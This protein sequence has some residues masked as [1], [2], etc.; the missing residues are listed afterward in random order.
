MIYDRYGRP[1]TSLRISLTRRCNLDC[2]YCHRE[3]VSEGG[4]EEMTP[5]EIERIIRLCA[6]S[7]IRRVKL[8]GGEPLL[9]RDIQEIVSRIS[10][11]PGIQD[12]SMTTNGVLLGEH[13]RSLREAGLHRVNVSLDTLR[14]EVFSWI[15]R[16]GDLARVRE[17]IERAVEVGLRP[18]K[19]NMVLLKGINEKEVWDLMKAYGRDGVVLQL[20]EL[21]DSDPALFEKY[22]YSLDHFE[23]LLEAE[24]REVV[25]RREMQGRKK[26]AL[27]GSEVEVIKPMHNTTFCRHC[28]RLRITADG[29]FKPCL[30]RSEN[31]VD[32][33]GPMREG[34][35]DAD[36]QEI[37][38]KAVSQR[39]PYF[40]A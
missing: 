31:T 27:N 28:T 22:Y 2:I 32:F 17:G 15:S 39:E 20:I 8:T 12:L 3:G 13:A 21:I 10:A 5:E 34:A 18:V 6:S 16:G 35:S 9:R 14:P 38:L 26:Y 25:T 7:G 36:L 11:V 29:R 24:A 23:S 4:E 30:M 1:L 33:L 19:V 37:L 40:K